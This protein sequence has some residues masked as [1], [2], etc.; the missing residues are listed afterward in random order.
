MKHFKKHFKIKYSILNG[1]GKEVVDLN[2]YRQDIK[3]N[4]IKHMV[5][6]VGKEYGDLSMAKNMNLDELYE[7]YA[8]LEILNKKPDE[9]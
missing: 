6:L 7:A 3:N 5:Y 8:A 2:R 1:N 9:S 4:T